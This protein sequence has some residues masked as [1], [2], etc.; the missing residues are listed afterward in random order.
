AV[1]VLLVWG[2]LRHF[3]G[4]AGSTLVRDWQPAAGAVLESHRDALAAALPDG[5]RLELEPRTELAVASTGVA[6]PDA[7]EPFPP[8]V[9]LELRRGRA[10]FDVAHAPRRQFRVRAGGVSVLVLGTRFSVGR[11]DGTVNVS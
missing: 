11:A 5:T 8:R 7:R 1:V 3:T 10:S 4:P 2:T 6:V 9:E